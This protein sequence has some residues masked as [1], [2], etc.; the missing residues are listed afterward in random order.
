LPQRLAWGLWT[1]PVTPLRDDAAPSPKPSRS[2]ITT[3][4]LVALSNPKALE[5]RKI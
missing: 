5:A 2:G 1:S 3:G 4:L